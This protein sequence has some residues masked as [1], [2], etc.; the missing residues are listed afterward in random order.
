MMPYD[1]YRLYQAGRPQSP[2]EVRCADERAGRLAAAA[3]RL[4][5]SVTPR[6]GP[7]RPSRSAAHP[8]PNRPAGADPSSSRTPARPR[9]CR[10]EPGD[11]ELRGALTSGSWLVE[12]GG[13]HGGGAHPPRVGHQLLQ[14][15]GIDLG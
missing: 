8:R 5:R 9:T 15:P 6:A 4:F 14:P 12:L 11:D 3:S 13:E 10:R 7:T 2:A 1:T